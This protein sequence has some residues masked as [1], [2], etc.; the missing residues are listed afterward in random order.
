MSA[1][2]SRLQGVFRTGLVTTVYVEFS[3]NDS[4]LYGHLK[5]V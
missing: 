1:V 5:V 2:I 4:L 3:R